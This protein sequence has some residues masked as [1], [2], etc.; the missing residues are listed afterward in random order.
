MTT[1]ASFPRVRVKPRTLSV[2]LRAPEQRTTDIDVDFILDFD[3][4]G[5]VLGIEILSLKRFAGDHILDGYDSE[6]PGEMRTEYDE[7]VDAFYLYL[8][9]IGPAESVAQ[10]EVTG[11]IVVDERGRML[12]LEAEL[13]DSVD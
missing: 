11:T 1:A 13:P 8:K 7:E 4:R 6:M 12:A 10:H 2:Q 3:A 9:H 5:D